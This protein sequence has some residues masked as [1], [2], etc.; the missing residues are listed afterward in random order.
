MNTKHTRRGFTQCCDPKGFTLIELLV[1]VLIIGILAAVAVP[2]YKLAVAKTHFAEMTL[3]FREMIKA[4]EMY[5]L[6]NGQYTDNMETLDIDF[7]TL[8]HDKSHTHYNNFRCN[9]STTYDEI[10]CHSQFGPN[11]LIHHYFEHGINKTER[12]PYCSSTDPLGQK[13]CQNWGGSKLNDT[14]WEFPL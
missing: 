1:V 10:Y 3:F 8:Q 13:L 11:I 6:A 12:E 9:V 4:E 5:Y 7:Q 2:Q 14:S